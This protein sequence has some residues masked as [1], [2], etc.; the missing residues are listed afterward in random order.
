MRQGLESAREIK[1]FL[2]P[3]EQLILKEDTKKVTIV[4]SQKSVEFFKE[5]SKVTHVPYQ[6]MIRKVLDN[7]TEA[8]SQKSNT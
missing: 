4:L 2:P 1:D 8:Y 7:Y 5:K 3:P 6:L